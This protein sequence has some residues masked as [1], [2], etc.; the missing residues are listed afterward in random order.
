MLKTEK[1]RKLWM[2]T[3][4]DHAEVAGYL[5]AHWGNE[6][7]ARPG[8]FASSRDPERLRAE[9]VLAIATHD[10]GWW[11]WE[12]TPELSDLD[13][14]PLHLSDVL[15][16]KQEGMNRWRLGIPRFSQDHP[17][18]S[19]LISFHAY[20]L[21]AHSFQ[22]DSDP[23]FI[24]P[25]FW[26]G[27]QL[28]H[29]SDEGLKN[30]QEFVSEI[31][32]IQNDLTSRL[33]K[34]PDCVDWIDTENLYPNARLLQLFDGLS[35]S[36]CSRLIPPRQG[37]AKG[38]GGDEFDLN[39]VPRGNWQ[40]RVTITLKPQGEGRIACNPY[41][42]D[43]DPLPVVVPTR[44]FQLPLKRS[45]SFQTWWHAHIPQLTRYEYCSA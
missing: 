34:D 1:D 42:F 19:L 28:Y 25:L 32:G 38:F 8:Y 15:K 43:V 26:K 13:G 44:I 12:A 9:T 36:I 14:L 31:K 16:N 2:I 40:D 39:D 21:Y 17:Y 27:S 33:G 4:P 45:T 18:V 24:H 5:A 3:Q 6:E 37:E 30:A 29:H 22:A 10:N 11:E 23:A 7:F 35:L 41:P 20:W